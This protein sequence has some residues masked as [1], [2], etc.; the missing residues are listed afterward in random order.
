MIGTSAARSVADRLF[1]LRHDAVV[2]RDDQHRDV[3]HVGT[4]GTHFG[5]RFVARR[6][7]E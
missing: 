4:A 2:G 5:E 6:I 7:D 1:G 3:G